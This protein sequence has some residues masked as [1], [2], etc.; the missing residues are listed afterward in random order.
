MYLAF[1]KDHFIYNRIFVKLQ[2]AQIIQIIIAHAQK[3]PQQQEQECKAHTRYCY[4]LEVAMNYVAKM[5][6]FILLPIYSL[7]K[8]DQEGRLML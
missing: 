6:M 1:G 4:K 5:A 3:K 8:Q 2:L 7:E